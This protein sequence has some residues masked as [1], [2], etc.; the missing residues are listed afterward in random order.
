MLATKRRP[1]V[2]ATRTIHILETVLCSYLPL[3]K[4]S[5]IGLVSVFFCVDFNV[6]PYFCT[7]RGCVRFGAPT[8]IA[9]ID[10]LLS[11]GWRLGTRIDEKISAPR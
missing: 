2:L 8:M 3:A 7:M 4:G 11:L 1:V 6:S 10:G 9:S 5:E